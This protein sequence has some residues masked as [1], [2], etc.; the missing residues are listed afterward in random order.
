MDI[1][2]L[3]RRQQVIWQVPK[4]LL[5]VSF[6]RRIRHAAGQQRTQPMQAAT[7]TTRGTIRA[8]VTCTLAH[9]SG[10]LRCCK[11]PRTASALHGPPGLACSQLHACTCS[12]L[13]TMWTA[14]M[15]SWGHPIPQ[16]VTSSNTAPLFAC[17]TGHQSRPA[18]PGP[19]NVM[20]P[21]RRQASG[22]GDSP[23]VNACA[24][25]NKG[26]RRGEQLTLTPTSKA[27]RR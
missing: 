21:A 26:L 17:I 2:L 23:E 1:P 11:W 25:Q 20:C 19:G 8:C 9:A 10:T 24:E 6:G 15:R 7:S 13:A 22:T 18:A 4:R 27:A 16:F 14:L 5:P 3:V 12:T